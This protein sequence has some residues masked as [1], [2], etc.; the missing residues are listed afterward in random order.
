MAAQRN[1]LWYTAH[2]AAQTMGKVDS[3][4]SQSKGGPAESPLGTLLPVFVA[5]GLPSC[6]CSLAAL[7][8]QNGCSQF[9]S[10]QQVAQGHLSNTVVISALPVSLAGNIGFSFY[11]LFLRGFFF[12]N[13]AIA[14]QRNLTYSLTHLLMPSILHYQY[15]QSGWYIVH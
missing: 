5:S 2:R 11:H 7:Y 9:C 1:S 12:S 3:K 15:H 8:S 14:S 6:G 10:N 4:Q 13:V